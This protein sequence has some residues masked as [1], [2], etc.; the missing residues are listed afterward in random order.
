MALVERSEFALGGFDV[1]F[2]F[3]N[4]SLEDLRRVIA[5]DLQ[6]LRHRECARLVQSE[7]ALEC[8]NVIGHA[9]REQVMMIGRDG[10][11]RDHVTR[12][13]PWP[14]FPRQEKDAALQHRPCAN[15]A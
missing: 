8:R 4:A 13:R 10:A 5:S 2:E 6:V 3:G 9:E 12:Q 7:L 11:S 15:E 14:R 1:T